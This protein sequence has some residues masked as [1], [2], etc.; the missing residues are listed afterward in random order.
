MFRQASEINPETTRGRKAGMRPAMPSSICTKSRRRNAARQQ[1]RFHGR[2]SSS[3]RCTRKSSWRAPRWPS[4]ARITTRQ[5]RLSGRPNRSSRAFSP[6]WYY[7][8]RGCAEQADH[9]GALANY[10][11]AREADPFNYQAM[12]LA[13]QSFRRI[14]LHADAA[15]AARDCV[16]HGRE[17]PEPLPGRRT[18]AFPR[19]LRTAA[20]WP[21]LGSRWLER[22]RRSARAG[23][24]VRQ[25]QRGLRVY[26][27]P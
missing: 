14:G 5:T 2:R 17:G 15:R 3:T 23:R 22:T 10:M 13:E 19:C 9:E 21:R 8:G 24:A 7:H 26:R 27:A 1:S 25:L 11:R 12:A 16:G 6:I 18:R 20:A 4:C